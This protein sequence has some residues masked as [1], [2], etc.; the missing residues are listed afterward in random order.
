MSQWVKGSRSSATNCVECAREGGAVLVRN[1]KNP[2]G[3]T[4]TF[5]KDEWTA[6]VDSVRG[7]ELG[8]EQLPA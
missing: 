5:T 3:A 8:Y 7:G 2:D 1:S 6:F 4:I